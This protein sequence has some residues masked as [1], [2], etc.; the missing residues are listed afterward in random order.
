MLKLEFF[1]IDTSPKTVLEFYNNINRIPLSISIGNYSSMPTSIYCRNFDDRNF[2]D[3]WFEKNTAVLYE[4][5]IIGLHKDSVINIESVLNVDNKQYYTCRIIEED[6][7]LTNSLT[8]KVLRTN[9][10]VQLIFDNADI[11]E[12]KYFQIGMNVYLGI[13]MNNFLKSIFV[14]N[15]SASNIYDIFGF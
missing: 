12:L 10:S 9:Q 5:V 13:D 3:L 4:I 15:L 14:D 2:I 1:L 6:S 7:E 11:S 8:V